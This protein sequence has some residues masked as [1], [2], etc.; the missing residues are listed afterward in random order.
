MFEFVDVSPDFRLPGLFVGGRFAAGGA[1]SMEGDLNRLVFYRD[2]TRKFNKNAPHFLNLLVL[3][4]QVLV[5]QKVAEPKFPGFRLG[6]SPSVEW[7]IFGSQLLGRV[8]SHPK[9]L[10]V[11][12]P[13][14]APGCEAAPADFAPSHADQGNNSNFEAGLPDW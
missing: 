7:S 9:R 12:H 14:L 2:G 6:L 11:D 13:G 8:A 3:A 5:P 1:A 4:Q 10:L